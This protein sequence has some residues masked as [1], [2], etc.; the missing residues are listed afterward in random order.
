MRTSTGMSGLVTGMSN[1]DRMKRP[2]H[3]FLHLAEASVAVA[4]LSEVAKDATPSDAAVRLI[5]GAATGGTSD[6][7]PRPHGSSNWP[8]TGTYSL[9]LITHDITLAV[10]P[11]R[12]LLRGL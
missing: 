9:L 10:H 8:G 12:F 4:T 5:V 2:R 6:I 11:A 3:R 1:G 7:V